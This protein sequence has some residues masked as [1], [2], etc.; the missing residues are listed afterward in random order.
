MSVVLKQKKGN[1]TLQIWSDKKNCHL[2]LIHE[3]FLLVRR[4]HLCTYYQGESF[5]YTL[6][7]ITHAPQDHNN[8]INV[9]LNNVAS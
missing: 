6:D 5:L 7:K 8:I 1:E 3:Y 2:P 9:N 4:N